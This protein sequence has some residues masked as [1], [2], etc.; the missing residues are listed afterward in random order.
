MTEPAHIP[1]ARRLYVRVYLSV[2]A[3][4]AVLV[5]MWVFAVHTHVRPGEFDAPHRLLAA[6]LAS[7]LPPTTATDGEQQ[8]A[9]AR[10]QAAAHVDIAL[11]AADERLLAAVGEAPW[12]STV[13]S[14]RQARLPS[15]SDYPLPLDDGRWL[16]LHEPT[17][18]HAPHRAAI[19]IGL[20]AI[21]VAAG[22][23]AIVRGLTRRL[24][25]L[26]RGVAVWGTGAL[27]ERVA[28][29]GRDE[30]AE[31][32]RSFNR[33]AE[34]VESVVRA[35]K[36]LLS[37]ASHELRSPL[38]RLRVAL[39]LLPEAT[40][41]SLRTEFQRNIAELDQL[42][43]EILLS[44]RL[45]AQGETALIRQDVDLAALAA[46]ECTRADATLQAQP[47]RLIGD[48]TLLR[49]LLRNL[50]ENARR[51]GGGRDVCVRIAASGDGIELL[52]SDRGPGIA[53]AERERVFEPFH[54]LRGASEEDGGVGLGLALV[55][56]IAQA[57]G[58]SAQCVEPELSGA[59]IRV[60]LPTPSN[61]H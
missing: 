44:S 28:V 29:E 55:R 17:Q 22:C 34:R 39:E 16:F 26:Q 52:V 49:R 53:A 32:A 46:E 10:W 4:V 60:R 23:F 57:H 38:A 19:L 8:S 58:G 54:R 45:D 43:G 14:L 2:L 13:P 12:R 48:A 21:A 3:I 7:A 51:H 41:E 37:N 30:I 56:Q 18:V 36:A 35:Q 20:M 40:T 9:L 61:P 25:R 50:I 24:E 11:Y 27:S 5:L 31:V 6:F 59:C 47:A 15:E 33:S 42:V 1:W